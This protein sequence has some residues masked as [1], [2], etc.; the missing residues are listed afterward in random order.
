MRRHEKQEWHRNHYRRSRRWNVR[1]AII[2]LR[3]RPDQC[4]HGWRYV[5]MYLRRADMDGP[6]IV[7]QAATVEL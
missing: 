7:L 6:W 1:E 2:P 5:R 3:E 4:R